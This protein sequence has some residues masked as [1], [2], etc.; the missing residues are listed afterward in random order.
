MRLPQAHTQAAHPLHAPTQPC[1]APRA[2]RARP[3]RCRRCPGIGGRPGPRPTRPSGTCGAQRQGGEGPG[4]EQPGQSG[5]E[6]MRHHGTACGAGGA[7]TELKPSPAHQLLKSSFWFAS[8]HRR[9]R[10]QGDAGALSRSDGYVQLAKRAGCAHVPSS[11]PPPGLHT[12]PTP[13]HCPPPARLAHPHLGA[14]RKESWWVAGQAG[15]STSCR[16]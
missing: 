11:W 8:L 2:S 16:R 4:G 13:P 5:A 12:P 3:A 7:P 10:G 15:R 9:Q 6:Q 1:A 14:D